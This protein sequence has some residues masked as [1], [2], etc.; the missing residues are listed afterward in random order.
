MTQQWDVERAVGACAS[1]GR[2]I[3]EGEE[4]YTVLFEE[5]DSF[6]RADYTLDAWDG[7]PEGAFCH[8]KTRLAAKEKRKKLFVDNEML[9]S[10]FRR[11]ANETEPTRLQFRFV[12]A[13]ILMR[14]RLIRYE[15][16]ATRDGVE[17][18]EMRLTGERSAHPVINPH[19]TDDQIETVSKQ[20]GAIL[21][22]DMGE[23]T[24]EDGADE[25]EGA[26]DPSAEDGEE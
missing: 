6:R 16:S 18:W 24:E 11:L 15:G 10:F 13:L 20:L 9:K 5:G 2:T 26:R 3:H 19:L 22:A 17:I 4:F 12:L 7:P 23:W 25:P 21:H 14:K 1:T 8:Y